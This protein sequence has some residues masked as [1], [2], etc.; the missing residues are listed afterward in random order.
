MSPTTI[1]SAAPHAALIGSNGTILVLDAGG[2]PAESPAW[3]NYAINFVAGGWH[4]SKISGVLASD[5]QLQAVLGELT[6]LFIAAEFV[7]PVVEVGGLDGVSLAALAP[8]PAAAWSLL[9]ALDLLGV[10]GAR[11]K[12]RAAGSAA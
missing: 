4:V 2:A 11:R 10:C 5:A 8:L 3:T 9:S 6:S 7:T 1:P 12:H